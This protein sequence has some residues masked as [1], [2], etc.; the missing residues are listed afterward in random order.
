MSCPG[1]S[2][3]SVT[4]GV[5]KLIDDEKKLFDNNL[6]SEYTRLNIEKLILH[7]RIDIIMLDCRKKMYFITNYVY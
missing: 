1:P 3:L 7:I 4:S 5:L 2:D 6:M